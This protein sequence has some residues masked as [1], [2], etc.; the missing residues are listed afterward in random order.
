[1]Y[2]QIWRETKLAPAEKLIFFIVIPF[3]WFFTSADNLGLD[4]EETK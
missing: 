2:L 1:M 4:D 3:M